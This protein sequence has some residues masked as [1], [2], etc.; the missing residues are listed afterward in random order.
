MNYQGRIMDKNT[1]EKLC[2]SC[3]YPITGDNVQD[4]VLC[5]Y[6]FRRNT[7]AAAKFLL[8]K[9][10]KS[11]D[12]KNGRKFRTLQEITDITNEFRRS[13]DK[14][15]VKSKA[16]YDILHRYEKYKPRLVLTRK[17]NLNKSGRPAIQY[18]MSLRLS[19]RVEY[20]ERRLKLGYT[21]NGKSKGTGIA[22]M[23]DD[24]KKS[25]AIQMKIRNGEYDIYKFLL[26]ESIME[27][28]VI[29]H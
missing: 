1:N 24:A 5:W 11:Y 3:N 27:L 29:S 26:K 22:I 23:G 13:I 21:I 7:L 15:E 14:P 9:S 2:L 10:L 16:V 28:K 6:C 4:K 19:K 18:R 8:F 12:E 25:R 17:K 20:Y